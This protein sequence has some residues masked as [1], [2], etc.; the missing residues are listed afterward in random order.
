MNTVR[1]G[2]FDDE[3]KKIIRKWIKENR[4]TRKFITEYA[5]VF[6]DEVKFLV[7]QEYFKTFIIQF[8]TGIS[9]NDDFTVYLNGILFLNNSFSYSTAC[10]LILYNMA[11]S[12]Y[13]K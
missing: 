4:I 3:R 9:F 10:F 13:S 11:I 8:I 12:L 1:T 5:P 7:L 6:P 2:F